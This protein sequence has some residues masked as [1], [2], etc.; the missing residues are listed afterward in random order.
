M[1]QAAVAIITRTKDRP[2]LLRRA[3]ES[4][5]GQTHADW[6]HVIVN[7]GG[8]P[9]AVEQVVAPQAA[10]SAASWWPVAPRWRWP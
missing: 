7:D 2:L 8:D 10:R 6:V 9:A 3:V 5:L 1:P 4:V